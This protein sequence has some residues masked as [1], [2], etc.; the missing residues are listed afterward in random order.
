M[1]Q[2]SS[3]RQ[4]PASQSR[5]GGATRKAPADGAQQPKGS[6]AEDCAAGGDDL[7]ASTVRSWFI[8]AYTSWNVLPVAAANA[9]ICAG[10]RRRR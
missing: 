10:S 3:Q 1:G 4:N 5:G 7:R 9:F 6:S 2:P 8:A